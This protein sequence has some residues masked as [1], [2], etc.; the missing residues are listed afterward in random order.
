M[1]DKQQQT[2][3]DPKP[4]ALK[5]IVLILLVTSAVYANSLANDFVADDWA[6]LPLWLSQNFNLL[7]VFLAKANSVEYL[8]VRDLSLVLDALLWGSRPFGYHLTSLILY[9]A[10]LAAFYYMVRNLAALAVDAGADFMAFW[11]TLVFALHPLHVEAV[12]FV[13]A[14]NNILAGLFLFLSFNVLMAGVRRGT[15]ILLFFSALSFAAALF[16]KASAVFYPL[17]LGVVFFFIPPGL[18]SARKKVI[19]FLVFLILGAG[20]AWVHL[21]NASASK[22]LNENYLRFGSGSAGLI[23]AKVVQIPFFYLWKLLLPYPLSFDYPFPLLS[24]S[25]VMRSVLAGVALAGLFVLLWIWRKRYI[26][27]VLGFAWYFLSLGPVLNIFPTTPVLADRYAY[28]AVGGFGL[29]FSL[30]LRRCMNRGRR[31]LYAA[32]AVLAIWSGIDISRNGDWRTD[33]TLWESAASVDPVSGKGLAVVLWEQKRYE[34][35]LTEFRRLHDLSGDFH[36]SQ[37]M[38]KYLVLSSRYE[39]AIAFYQKAL[40]EG[41]DALKE[42]HLDLA[43]A[44]EKLGRDAQALEHYLKATDATSVDFLGQRE[45]KAREGIVRIRNR[46][47][48]K[49]EELRLQAEREPANFRAQWELAFFLQSLGMFD[50]A[51]RVYGR[52]LQLHSSSWE[53]WYNLGLISMKRGRWKEAV[54]GLD[55]SLA[56]NP[57]NKDA[58]NNIGICYMGMKKYEVAANYYRRALEQDPDFFFAAFNLGRAYFI[59]GDGK[60]ARYYFSVARRIAGDNRQLQARMEPYLSQLK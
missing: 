32:V 33:L 45:E 26:L 2:Q 55:R 6:Q 53:G 15:K 42:T 56:L 50:E 25:Y 13:S 23:A 7:S 47:L 9:L 29:V 48:P 60:Q 31:F 37:Y 40:A 58:L 30:V 27:A 4:Q 10:A 36:Y 1:K 44:Y 21:A 17:F 8:P 49:V 18:M 24:G 5:N 52:V 38:G 59:I 22:V 54:A 43:E 34:E 41:G 14:R 51:E 3:I 12:S 28:F 57:R 11:A 20:G 46:F 35:A 39:E 16:S 19:L